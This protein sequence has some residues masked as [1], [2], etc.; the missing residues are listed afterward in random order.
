MNEDEQE[1]RNQDISCNL[2]RIKFVSQWSSILVTESTCQ[3]NQSWASW[4]HL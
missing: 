4:I 3:R 2:T 1:T